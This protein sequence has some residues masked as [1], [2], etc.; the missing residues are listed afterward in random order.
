MAKA[1]PETMRLKVRLPDELRTALKARQGNNSDLIREALG[2]LLGG[3][4]SALRFGKRASEADYALQVD[5]KKE[6]YNKLADLAAERDVSL[7]AIVQESVRLLLKKRCEP[8]SNRLLGANLI[9]HMDRLHDARQALSWGLRMSDVWEAIVQHIGES[10]PGKCSIIDKPWS[11]ICHRGT[12]WD[13]SI[14]QAFTYSDPASKTFVIAFRVAY[15]IDDEDHIHCGRNVGRRYR[16]D[17]PKSL[18]LRF[19][20]TGFTTWLRERKKAIAAERKD[21]LQRRARNLIARYP[22]AEKILKGAH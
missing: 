9:E 7:N 18:L 22:E 4:V 2:N 12:G 1:K 13:I 14:E 17:V 8:H 3:K 5:I 15:Q 21:E 11:C 20:K 10:E 16:I 6:L 19:T